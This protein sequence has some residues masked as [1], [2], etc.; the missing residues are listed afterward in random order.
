MG[1]SGTGR[2]TDYSGSSEKSQDDASKGQA[3]TGSG[4]TGGSSGTDRCAQVFTTDLED[5]ARSAYF[6][7]D[8]RLP[9]TGTAVDVQLSGRLIASV[10]EVELGYL[11][12]QYNYLAGCMK[13]GFSYAGTVTA[14]RMTPTPSVTVDIAPV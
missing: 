3:S 1:S 8:G 9:P 2:F 14:T 13:R 7:A 10:G 4:P 12:T 6:A 5:V 11:P